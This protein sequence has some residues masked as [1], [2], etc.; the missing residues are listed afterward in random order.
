MVFWFVE[1]G[2]ESE[3][4]ANGSFSRR[5]VTPGRDMNF[6][7]HIVVEVINIRPDSWFF[8]GI[9][10]ERDDERFRRGRWRSSSEGRN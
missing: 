1:R 8:V 3:L 9:D 7:E 10:A 2:R 6:V 5:K 4:I